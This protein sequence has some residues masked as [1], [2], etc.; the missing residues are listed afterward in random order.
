M[1]TCVLVF[2]DILE[3]VYWNTSKQIFQPLRHTHIVYTHKLHMFIL[4]G[5]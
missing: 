1:C 3:L 4:I 5:S 2:A